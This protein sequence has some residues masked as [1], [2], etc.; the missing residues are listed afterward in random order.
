MERYKLMIA[1]KTRNQSKSFKFHDLVEKLQSIEMKIRA[2]YHKYIGFN[3]ET[4]LWIMAVDSSFLIEFL[5][6]YSFR[7]VETLINRVGHNEILRDIMMIENQ[8]PL[9]VLRK[10]LEF[11]LESTES[12]DDLLV[13]VLTGLC[14]D[15]SPLVIK[16]DDDEIL[17]AQFHECNHILDFLYQMIVP[18]IEEEELEEEEDEENRADDNGGNRAIRFLEEIKYQ[19]KRVFASRPADL[20]L[21]FPWRI[22]SNLP[23]FMALKLSADYLFTRQENE[24]TTTRRESSSSVSIPDIEK[25]P[26]VEELTIPSV[27][28]LHK[29]GVRFKPTTHGNISTVTFDSN[30]GQFHLPVINL[31]INTETV[32]RNLVAYEA[33]NTSGPL[34]FT[35]YTE[36][37]NGIIDSEE[38]VR[39]LREQGVLVS[40]LK[41]DQEAAEMW[42]G[43]SKSVRLTK[44]GFLDKTIEDVNRYYTGRW[45]VKI[46]RLVEVYVY[47]SWQILAFL[48]AVLLLMLVSL[49]LFSLV[50]SSFL[51]SQNASR[52]LAV[53][54]ISKKKTQMTPSLTSLSRFSYLES[55]GNAY[56]RNIRFFSASPPTEENPVSLPTDEIPIS[57]AAELTLEESVASALGFSESGDFGVNGG[58]SMEA[59]GGVAE[60][61]DSEIVAIENEVSEV[62]QFDDEKLES[63]LCLLRSDE[64]SLEFGL[65]AL[66]VD[67]H[68]DF[69]VRVFESPGISGKNLIRFLKWATLNEE[70]T[71]TT[72]LVESLLVAIAGDTRRMDAYGL[73]DLV[74]EIGEKENTSVLN[75]EILNELIALF[76][77]LGKSKAAFDVFSKTQEFGFTPN[78]KTYY[79]TL[80]ALCKR[81]FMDWACSV[82][83]KMLKSGVLPE[84]EQMG[85]IITWFSKEGKAEEA[86]SVYELAKTKEKSL[87]PRSVATLISALCKNDGTITFAQEM[88]SDLS[89]EARRRGIKPFSDVIHSLC[90]M[91]NVKDAKALLLDMIS[92]GPA[93]GNAVF[94]LIVHACSKTGDLDEAKEVLKLME[95]RGL[96]PDVYTYTVIISGY[97]K[98]GMM[99]E[100]QEILAEAKKKHKKLSPVT[101][102]ALIR[103]YCKIEEYD[104]ALKLLKEMD[105]FGV[106]PNADEYNKLIQSFC[107]KALDWEKAEMLFEE[108]KQKGL[109]LN[110]ISQGLIRA[111]KEMESEAKVTEDDNL[112]AEA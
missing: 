71:V 63:V 25:P 87:P 92:K 98:G 107:L 30:S 59:V 75:L 10:T 73:W 48:A 46:G 103:G 20:I 64:E 57:S 36:L 89:G 41:S 104:E 6:I 13:S 67:L 65:N 34:V 72:S 110:A 3:G 112:L 109:H 55:S 111:V 61:G 28:D 24:A 19:F 15:L 99:N 86:Y 68:L 17:K 35:R 96:K 5:K 106:Q 102:H 88:L 23:G 21:R 93:P 78:A 80:E 53:T 40:R 39:L 62:Y 82:C 47:G 79:L 69:V 95:S 32:L 50:F 14:R 85:N 4:L 2:C 29:A 54:R 108:M 60:Y 45:K 52:N 27:S 18:R 42:N 58:T 100:A 97:A 31:D 105:R 76:G 16:F 12:A 11:Q 56:A 81:S 7:K 33:S 94:N 66:N 70:I 1:R 77:K 51:R 22:I 91:R 49:Q 44:V 37:I 26:L 38:D 9:F 83:E 101:Y 43:M 90:R 8:I 84:G 74:K